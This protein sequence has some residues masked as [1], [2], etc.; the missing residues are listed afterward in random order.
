[1]GMREWWCPPGVSDNVHYIEQEVVASVSGY[2]NTWYGKW[3]A[4][5]NSGKYGPA[6]QT[7]FSGLL[8]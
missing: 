8:T 7:F 4:F 3:E 5:F 2:L 6:I 1:M